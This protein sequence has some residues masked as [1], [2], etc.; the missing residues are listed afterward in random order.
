MFLDGKLPV[1]PSAVAPSG[2]ISLVR[3]LKSFVVPRALAIDEIPDIIAAYKT[4]AQNAML[5]GFDGVE[6]HG[7]NGYLLD[8]FLQDSTNLRNDAYGGPIENRARLMLEVAD[9]VIDVWGAGRVGMHLAPA[10]DAHSMGDSNPLATFTYVAKELGKRK[11]A[12][13]FARETIDEHSIGAQLKQAFDG[14]Y[15]I[16]QLLTKQSATSQIKS[17]NYC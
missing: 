4:G 13:L 2:H 5:A 17:G 9:A 11:L 8:Q 14:A 1:A 6:I 10:C 7:A 16:N 15:I 3:P 12:F